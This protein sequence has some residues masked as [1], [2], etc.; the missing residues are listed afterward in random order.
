MLFLCLLSDVKNAVIS[1]VAVIAPLIDKPAKVGD[2]DV[3][4]DCPIAIVG[5]APSPLLLESVTPVPATKLA[6]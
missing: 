1:P 3:A 2:A 4:T 5:V 6:T